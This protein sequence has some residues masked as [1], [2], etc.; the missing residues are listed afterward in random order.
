MSNGQY[1]SAISSAPTMMGFPFAPAAGRVA[2]HTRVFAYGRNTSPAAGEDVWEGNAV[3]PFQTAATAMEIL[4]SSASDAAA[5]TGTRTV[6]VSGL[7]LNF[8]PISETVTMNG[9][10]VVALVNSY[11]RINN[12]TQTSAGSNQVNVGTITLRVHSAG[13][14]QAIMA[15]GYGYSKLGL[16]TIPN[17]FSLLV[18]DL[19]LETGGTGTAS[20]CVFGFK[21]YFPN[22]GSPY[23]YI[24]NEYVASPQLPVQRTVT[25][26]VLIPQTVSLVMTITGVTGTPPAVYAGFEGILI[27]NTQLT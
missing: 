6:L 13:A 2:G 17:G 9:T 25:A 15:I 26:G 27:D 24:T 19:L 23:Y 11:L 12:V 20:N 18:T 22:A 10:S 3:Y 5:G 4:S 1:I 16:Y 8:N 21:R 14:T 7:D